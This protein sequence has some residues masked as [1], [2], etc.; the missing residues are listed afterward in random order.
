MT[1][2]T[3]RTGQTRQPRQANKR[4][5]PSLDKLTS[6]ETMNARRYTP[7]SIFFELTF[8]LPVCRHG[9]K[10]ARDLNAAHLT[11]LIKINL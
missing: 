4:N 5:A 9:G 6:Q 11:S 7:L 3:G 8:T 1:G 10:T 2:L